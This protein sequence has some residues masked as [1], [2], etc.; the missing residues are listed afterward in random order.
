LSV[1][2]KLSVLLTSF[3]SQ[4]QSSLLPAAVAHKIKLNQQQIE[5]NLSE[6]FNCEIRKAFWSEKFLHLFPFKLKFPRK[7]L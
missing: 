5:A 3:E 7:S 1:A 6:L 4:H 2:N